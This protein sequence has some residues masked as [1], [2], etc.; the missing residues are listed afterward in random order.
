MPENLLKIK[1]LKC[2]ENWIQTFETLF[3]SNLARSLQIL[4][5]LDSLG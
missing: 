3:V 1:S 2:I 4:T 5:M